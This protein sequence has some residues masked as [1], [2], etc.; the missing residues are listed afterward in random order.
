MYTQM[1]RFPE[2]LRVN[3]AFAILCVVMTAAAIKGLNVSAEKLNAHAP[4]IT[5]GEKSVK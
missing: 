4:Y 3:K 2:A 5:A 1:N